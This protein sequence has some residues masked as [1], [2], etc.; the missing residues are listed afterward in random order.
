MAAA[1]SKDIAVINKEEALRWL[2]GAIKMHEVGVSVHYS[3]N[4]RLKGLEA[5]EVV[6][7]S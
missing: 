2:A 5:S 4:R 3:R 7:A 1:R 6:L